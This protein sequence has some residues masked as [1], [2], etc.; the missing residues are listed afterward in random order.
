MAAVVLGISGTLNPDACVIGFMVGL[1]VG[2]V[3]TFMGVVIT[4]WLC[5]P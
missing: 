3:A 5:K 2:I 4:T 1:C